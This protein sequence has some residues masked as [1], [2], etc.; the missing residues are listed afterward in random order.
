MLRP[1]R[2]SAAT[3]IIAAVAILAVGGGSATAAKLITGKQIRN[4]SITGQDIKKGSIKLSDIG[5]YNGDGVGETFTVETAEVTL[6]P[7]AATTDVLGL[8]DFKAQCPEDTTVIGTGFSGPVAGDV[9][10][11]SKFGTFVGAWM[12]N[13]APIDV[14]VSIQAI[15]AYGWESDSGY[16]SASSL[17]DNPQAEFERAERR[18][19][20]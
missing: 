9:G 14:T 1:K 12:V 19:Q 18:H 5:F 2:P 10:F 15:C 6:P 13:R 8:G 4:S 7:G 17:R 11:V 3:I 20:R 16:L